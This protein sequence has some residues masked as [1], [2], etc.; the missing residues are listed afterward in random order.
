MLQFFKF[1]LKI[2]KNNNF[3]KF[4]IGFVGLVEKEWIETINCLDYDDIIYESFVDAGRRL[5]IELRE[6]DVS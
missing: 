2:S 6:H 1:D 5:A 3:I 4:Q